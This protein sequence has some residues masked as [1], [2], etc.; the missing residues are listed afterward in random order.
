M[1]AVDTGAVA[2][3]DM[4]DLAKLLQNN[5]M[6]DYGVPSIVRAHGRVRP[7]EGND[8]ECCVFAEWMMRSRCADRL[9]VSAGPRDG[10]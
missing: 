1:T 3:R 8:D 7:E 4:A 2:I 6:F 5:A 9:G 10:C